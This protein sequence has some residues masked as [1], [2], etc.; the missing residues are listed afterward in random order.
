[1]GEVHVEGVFV[2]LCYTDIFGESPAGLSGEP[3]RNVKIPPP[4]QLLIEETCSLQSTARLVLYFR[5][6]VQRTCQCQAMS[7]NLTPL[8]WPCSMINWA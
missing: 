5:Y 2:P 3:F 1:M 4:K 8:W 7:L 6:I